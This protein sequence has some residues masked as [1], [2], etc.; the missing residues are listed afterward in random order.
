MSSGRS[1]GLQ[2]PRRDVILVPA[3]LYGDYGRRADLNCMTLAVRCQNKEI[4]TIE[5]LAEGT[6]LHPMQ[7]AF[8]K[9][10]AIQCGYCT[11][12]MVL[13]SKALLDKAPYP[14]EEEVRLSIA[15]N[16]CHCTG[17]KKIVEAVMSM[18]KPKDDSL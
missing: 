7:E 15:G 5:G 2:A 3:G 11:P 12:G 6:R 14:S 9:N 10:G 16:L 4:L 18:A 13:S 1:W 17:Y 8:I